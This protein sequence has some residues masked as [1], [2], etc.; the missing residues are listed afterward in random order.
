LNK[1]IIKCFLIFL[2]TLGILSNFL[3]V[4]FE[5]HNLSASSH[6]GIDTGSYNKGALSILQKKDIL[7]L[8]DRYHSQGFQIFLAGFFSLCEHKIESTKVLFC[9][10][11]LFI[12][13]LIIYAGEKYFQP[14]VGYLAGVFSAFSAAFKIYAATIQYEI[15]VT[16]LILIF[17]LLV[18]EGLLKV[19]KRYFIGAGFV[20]S[21][22][23]M[24]HVRFI[25]LILFVPFYM[26][27]FLKS[28]K[29]S[30]LSSIILVVCS[31]SL[32]LPW[33][34][35]QSMRIKRTVIIQSPLYFQT[36]LN[37]CYNPHAKGDAN[38][39]VRKSRQM[40]LNFIMR[41]PVKS[42]ILTKERFLHF[43]NLKANV[44]SIGFS[45]I[46]AQGLL[47]KQMGNLCKF[48]GLETVFIVYYLLLFIG[49]LVLFY[50]KEDTRIPRKVLA[51]FCIVILSIIIV[52]LLVTGSPR[53]CVPMLPYIYLFQS[54]FIC[55]CL[56]GIEDHFPSS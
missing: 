48:R 28:R 22:I 6:W 12:T 40:G 42:I 13:L 34:I 3:F 45:S 27:F 44:N 16:L 1:S 14:G 30:V 7:N 43:W 33:S 36:A 24:V 38:P 2:I 35:Y 5:W 46:V 15:L 56:K 4:F 54:Y 29:N 25:V 21:M 11:V 55:N 31:L 8:K 39:G 18:I 17:S 37:R 47:P 41:H 51:I 32:I 9:E 20:L 53:F 26:A 23:C 10:F 19:K 49:G 52:P 50:T